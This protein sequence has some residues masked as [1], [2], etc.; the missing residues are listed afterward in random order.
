MNGFGQLIV[1]FSFCVL[2]AT[3]YGKV[4]RLETRVEQLETNITELVVL[5]AQLEKNDRD[6]IN[7]M[8]RILDIIEGMGEPDGFDAKDNS[9]TGS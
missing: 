9:T 3:N 4:T 6:V 8:R 2:I 5:N 7:A 1:I